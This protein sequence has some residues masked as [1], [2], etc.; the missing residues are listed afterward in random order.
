MF[1]LTSDDQGPSIISFW[2]SLSQDLLASGSGDS[3]ARIWNLERE[4]KEIVLRHCVNRGGQE[5]S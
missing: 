2:P 5:A 1:I 3:T 4:Q